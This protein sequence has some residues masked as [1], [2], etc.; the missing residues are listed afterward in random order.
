MVC[1]CQVI[2]LNED[3][4]MWPAVLKRAVKC[5]LILPHS[6]ARVKR[7]NWK[8]AVIVAVVVNAGGM[9]LQA[10]Q[11]LGTTQAD[12]EQEPSAIAALKKYDSL[13]SDA[14]LVV[15]LIWF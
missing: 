5:Q 1:G 13:C 3:V 15:F 14:I 12:N 6:G 8:P 4:M 7:N 9:L 2:L 10:W 11:Y